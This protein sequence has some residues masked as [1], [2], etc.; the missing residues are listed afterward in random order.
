M[1]IIN[2]YLLISLF[3]TMIVLYF[4]NPNPRIIIQ[5]PS[6]ENEVSDL[7]IDDQNVCYKYHRI[8][9]D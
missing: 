6:I 4:I 9:I 2:E 3:V 8:E 5:N 7:Y 1:N